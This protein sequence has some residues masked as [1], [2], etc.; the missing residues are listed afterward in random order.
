[1]F[2]TNALS[3]LTVIVPIILLLVQVF[4]LIYVFSKTRKASVLAYLTYIVLG[5]FPRSYLL[6]Y[7]DDLRNN[8]ENN[9]TMLWLGD[10]I[11][12]RI[13]NFLYLERLFFALFDFLGLMLFIWL[14]L[15]ILKSDRTL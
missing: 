4:F 13:A 2:F 15:S 10:S 11:G 7:L 5:F 8:I 1:M 6:L 12:T 14:I 9:N 3:L